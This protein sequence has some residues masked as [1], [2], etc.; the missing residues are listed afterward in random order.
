[1]KLHSS[2]SRRVQGTNK[3]GLPVLSM[4]SGREEQ[5]IQLIKQ[6]IKMHSSAWRGEKKKKKKIATFKLSVIVI[7]LYE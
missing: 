2:Q 1:M 7:F 6:Q 5:Y 3:L 4:A